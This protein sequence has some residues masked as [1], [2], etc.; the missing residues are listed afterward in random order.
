MLAVLGLISWLLPP[1]AGQSDP[2]GGGAG[3]GCFRLLLPNA[4]Q[5][6]PLCGGD[7]YGRCIQL[8]L[9]NAEQS[10]PRCG[11]PGCGR[12][13]PLLPTAG[14]S[15]PL[16][17]GG[18]CGRCFMHLVPKA[19]SLIL[20]AE[21]P[22]VGDAVCFCCRKLAISSSLRRRWLWAF[23]ASAAES[24]QS[25]PLCGGVGCGQFFL[26]LL[27]KAGSLILSVVVPAVG[28]AFY[29]CCRTLGS[30]ILAA[31]APAVGDALSFCRLTILSSERIISGIC[32][33]DIFPVFW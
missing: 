12:F 1:N 33:L 9:P 16:C 14:Q 28:N 31:E 18:G 3:C 25:D 23:S 5:S 30:L 13:L 20:S 7:D 11:G 2:L 32:F 15:D 8:L 21:A 6:E 17:G 10:D 27:P 22:A 26:L 29:F 24:W 4:G 19:G